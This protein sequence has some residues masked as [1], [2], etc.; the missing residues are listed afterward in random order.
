MRVADLLRTRRPSRL[1]T[2]RRKVL[3][4]Q[5]II[6]TFGHHGA[7]ADADAAVEIPSTSPVEL[8]DTLQIDH[9]RGDS[10]P[11]LTRTRRSVP[12]PAAP[13]PRHERVT[14][15]RAR[16]RLGSNVFEESAHNASNRLCL[17]HT[18]RASSRCGWHLD[19]LESRRSSARS[20][21]LGNTCRSCKA[22]HEVDVGFEEAQL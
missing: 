9:A 22:E 10:Q 7:C 17:C 8:G 2:Q 1:P 21:C 20:V 18:G 3:A 4:D 11:F 16:E 5:L 19:P 12:L 13:H 14:R 15:Q 6:E